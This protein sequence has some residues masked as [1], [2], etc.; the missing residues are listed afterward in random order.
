MNYCKANLTD[1]LSIKQMEKD[2]FPTEAFNIRL[3]KNLLINPKSIV[4]K[5]AMPSGKIV[6]DI[7]G[8]TKK[9]N[10]IQVGRIFSL[11]VLEEYR[12]KGIATRLLKLLEEEFYLNSIRKVFLEVSAHNFIA[13]K[14]YQRHGYFTTSSI[15]TNFYNDGSDA[16]VMSKNLP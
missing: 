6:A 15:L 11:C 8:I 4:I 12:K 5:A 16:F 9:E 7:I 3:I 2:C 10:R 14:F 1:L 13:Q